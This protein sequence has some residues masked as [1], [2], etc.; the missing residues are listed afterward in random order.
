MDKAGKDALATAC[1]EVREETGYAVRPDNLV[2]LGPVRGAAAV[3][4]QRVYM[5][6]AEVADHQCVGIGGGVE[7]EGENIGV[8]RLQ[9]G[10][11]VETLEGPLRVE[12]TPL[13]AYMLLWFATHK[14][15]FAPSLWSRGRLLL[16]VA[17]SATLGGALGYFAP[18]LLGRSSL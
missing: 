4:G 13:T 18:R 9:Y 1:A 16:A 7:E 6:Y 11:V 8:V 17:A 14:L 5:Y 3:A 2:P 15:G 12:T 10:D